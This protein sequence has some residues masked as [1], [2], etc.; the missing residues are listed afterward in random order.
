VKLYRD[1]FKSKSQ[2][3][4]RILNVESVLF[5]SPSIFKIP[6]YNS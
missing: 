6:K 2:I 5:L 3:L 4:R 1:N